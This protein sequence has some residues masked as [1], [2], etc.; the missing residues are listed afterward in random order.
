MFNLQPSVGK[1][2]AEKSSKLYLIGP[3]IL[4]VNVFE[5]M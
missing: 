3:I 5:M 4:I 1:Y 2:L